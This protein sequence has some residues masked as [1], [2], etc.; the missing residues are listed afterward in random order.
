MKTGFSIKILVVILVVSVFPTW[1]CRAAEPTKAGV[2]PAVSKNLEYL[3]AFLDSGR[4]TDFDSRQIQALMRFV[5]RPKPEDVL[6]T[7]GEDFDTNSAYGEFDI[8]TGF[9]EFL[10]FAFNPDVPSY[11]LMPASVRR[12]HWK[13]IDGKSQPLPKLWEALPNLADAITVRGVEFVENTPDLNSGAY[14]AYDLDKLLIL[15]KHAGRFVLLSISKQARV[16]DIGKKGVILGPDDDW[17]YLYSGQ[18]G[19]ARPGLGWV[20]SYMYDSYSVAVYAQLEKGRPGVRCGTFKWVNAGWS[21][22]NMVK[23]EHIYRGLERYA[24]AFKEVL[25]APVLPGVDTIAK[26]YSRVRSY[27]LTQL[28]SKYYSYLN[29]DRKSVV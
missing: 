26:T 16:S 10:K 21:R 24:K 19:I 4:K 17:T 15:T 25:E 29:T 11:L 27:S 14:F 22:I 2:S 1:V 6:Y 3:L 7:T 12:S 5:Y 8:N 23:K 18:N 20:D 13:T 9:D 28:K